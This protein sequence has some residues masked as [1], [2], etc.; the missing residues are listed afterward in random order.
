MD[1]TLYDVVSRRD[2]QDWGRPEDFVLGEGRPVSS[3]L[4]V[5]E[6][7]WSLYTLDEVTA[8]AWFVDLPPELNLSRAPFVYAAQHQHARRVLRVPLAALAALARSVPGPEHVILVFSTGRCGS[9]LVS[10]A[11]SAVPGVWSLSEPDAYTRLASEGLRA[12]K[13]AGYTPEETVRLIQACTRLQFRPPSGVKVHT[14]ALKFRS[15]ASFQAALYHRA[16]PEASFVFLYREALSWAQS[17][18]RMLR[19][20]GLPPVLTGDDRLLTWSALSAG[21]SIETMRRFVDVEA[22]EV[23]L[24]DALAPAWGLY[25]EEYLR[26][27]R[28]GVPF[29]A[30]RYDELNA[31]RAGSLRR[32]F[33]HC[34]LPLEAIGPAL[35]AYD[36]DSQADTWMAREVKTDSLSRVQLAKLAGLL[37]RYPSFGDP[38]HWL[39][40]FYSDPAAND[41][42]PLASVAS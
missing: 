11:L 8:S 37:A 19:K 5:Q 18:Y 38:N 22:D 41:T 6:V 13:R 30:L 23:A 42:R 14:L 40:D 1:A 31:D 33:R 3:R 28:G 9:T 2:Q 27:L 17:F 21:A 15:Q 34:G 26:Q 20:F 12:T 16:L 39:P 35:A 24:E 25:M 4:V 7:T 10:Q 36:R 29:L 32:L